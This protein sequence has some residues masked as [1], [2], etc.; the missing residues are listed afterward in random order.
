M[1]VYVNNLLDFIE[2]ETNSLL[3]HIDPENTNFEAVLRLLPIYIKDVQQL[4]KQQRRQ[5]DKSNPN[6]CHRCTCRLEFENSD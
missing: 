4:V 6:V 3:E 5:H 2:I 1:G